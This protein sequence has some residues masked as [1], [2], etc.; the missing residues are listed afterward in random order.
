MGLKAMIVCAGALLAG[1]SGL[2]DYPGNTTQ[3]R[4]YVVQSGDTLYKIA[5]RYGVDHRDLAAWNN[6]RNPDRIFVGQRLTL[7][8]PSR[9]AGSTAAAAPRPAAASAPARAQPLPAQPSPAWQWPVRGPVVER[10]GANS[11]AVTGIR[12]GGLVGQEVAAAAGGRVVYAGSGLVGYG[13][14]VI[15]K[16]NETYLSAY[17]Y[18]S[19]L[20]VAE[21]QDVA[22]GQVIAEMGLGPQRQPRLHF[23]IRR[24]GD[25]ID[26]LRFLGS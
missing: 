25:P 21:G 9:S 14:L 18:N 23:E 11:G 24:N 6:L 12:I 22:R 4:S 15:I 13:Q 19:R 10:F 2:Y 16:H 7:Y 8:S 20:L 1:C 5:W 17:G 3:A 26:P